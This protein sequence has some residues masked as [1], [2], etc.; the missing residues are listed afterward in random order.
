MNALSPSCSAGG[1]AVYETVSP[2]PCVASSVA[3][4]ART[5]SASP[6][7]SGS[8]EAPQMAFA[9]AQSNVGASAMK[10]SSSAEAGETVTRQRR[11]SP[12]TMRSTPA[13]VPPVTPMALS[14]V[15]LPWSVASLNPSASAWLKR[16]SKAMSPAP[17]WV[18]GAST[19]SAVSGPAGSGSADCV[20]ERAGHEPE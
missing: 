12:A 9:A 6:T 5:A 17:S 3:G 8:P 13:S 2:G 11:V 18:A 10:T 20:E 19:N 4:A 7:E 14:T 15:S 1:A 16:S